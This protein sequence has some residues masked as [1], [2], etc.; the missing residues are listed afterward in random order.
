[1]DDIFSL[2][3]FAAAALLAVCTTAVHAQTATG[4]SVKQPY[5]LAMRSGSGT[6]TLT[7]SF[8]GEAAHAYS[9]TMHDDGS[10]EVTEQPAMVGYDPQTKDDLMEGLDRLGA[11]AKE[12]NEVNLDKNMMALAGNNGRYA[13]LSSKIDLITVRNYEFAQKGQYQRSDLDGL[14]RKLEGNGWSHIIRNESTDESND[15]VIKSGGDG[16]ISDMVILNAESREVN[17]VHIRGHFRMEDV[18]GAMGR[19]MGISHGAG[20]SAMGPLMGITGGSSHS[21]SRSKSTSSTSATPATPATPAMPAT[22]ASPA[23]PR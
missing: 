4:P 12:R 15:I 21:S 3:Q 16:F 1:M 18:N 6:T 23:S 11:N 22:P 19:V 9:V 17:V 5:M 14:R 8:T 7:A 10:T 20:A 13:D 2:R